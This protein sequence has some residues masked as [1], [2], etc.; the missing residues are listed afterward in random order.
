[1]KSG[2]TLTEITSRVLTGLDEVIK[3]YSRIRIKKISPWIL[4]ILRMGIYQIA[5]LDKIPESAAVNE[6]VNL[7]KKYGH[8]VSSKF[9][10]AILRKISKENIIENKT[11]KDVVEDKNILLLKKEILDI[12]TGAGGYRG[13]DA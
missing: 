8:E 4:N 13:A 10:N 1:M 11:D 7:A 3:K 9:V 12:R 5:F 6:S 2:Q